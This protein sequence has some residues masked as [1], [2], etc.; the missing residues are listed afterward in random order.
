MAPLSHAGDGKEPSGT[1]NSF[2][3]FDSGRATTGLPK[4]TS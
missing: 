1:P 2:L 3:L 4:R